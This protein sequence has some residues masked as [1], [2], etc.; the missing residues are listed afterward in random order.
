MSHV[1]IYTK[2]YCPYCV[3]ALSVLEQKGVAFTEIEAAFD[4]EKR[5]EMVR[6]A[7]G[8]ATFPQ[9]FVGDLHIGGCDEMMALERAGELDPLLRDAA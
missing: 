4:P 7:G 8:R 6:R 3:R 1:T 9:I 2:P 5:Q